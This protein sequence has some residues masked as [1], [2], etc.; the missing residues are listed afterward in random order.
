MAQ[1]I[2]KFVRIQNRVSKRPNDT[3]PSWRTI[4]N[5]DRVAV[6]EVSTVESADTASAR[7]F[8]FHIPYVEGVARGSRVAYLGG[9]FD[10]VRTSD[11]TKLRGLEL[12]CDPL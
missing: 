7:Q 12:L 3:A 9:Q 10:V 1:E 2:G 4:P 6:W 5:C 11:S 8:V